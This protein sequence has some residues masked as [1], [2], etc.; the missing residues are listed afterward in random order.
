MSVDISGMQCRRSICADNLMSYVF[1]VA[2]STVGE[3]A[4]WAWGMVCWTLGRPVTCRSVAGLWNPFS[5]H[6]SRFCSNLHPTGP[7]QWVSV[8]VRTREGCTH[9]V[10]IVACVVLSVKPGAGV[11]ASV[12]LWRHGAGGH[13]EELDC[14]TLTKKSLSWYP[15]CVDVI[16][17]LTS[18][19]YN[20][21][22]KYVYK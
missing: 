11:E 9:Y 22:C 8:C 16:I 14:M 6:L 15:L 4:R 21:E 3:E 7:P 12:L 19:L 17:S 13:G 1:C 2:L 10:I 5:G 20:N 18:A